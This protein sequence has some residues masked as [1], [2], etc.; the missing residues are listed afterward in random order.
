MDRHVSGLMALG[1]YLTVDA[2]VEGQ[3]DSSSLPLD[4]CVVVVACRS[5]IE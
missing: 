5:K 1:E 2:E 4:C 3:D